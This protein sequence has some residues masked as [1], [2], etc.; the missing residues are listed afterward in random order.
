MVVPIGGGGLISGIA[1]AVKE[2]RPATRVFGVEPTGANA[3][4]LALDTGEPVRIEPR[5][6]ADGLTA[7]FAG[8]WTLAMCRRYLDGVVVI[9]D[10]TILGGCG[11]RSSE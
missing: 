4:R 10:A 8:E 3:M 2:T 6:V 7:P 11:S 1:T 5:T 9:D